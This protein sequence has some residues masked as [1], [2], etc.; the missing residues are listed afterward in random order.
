[1]PDDDVTPESDPPEA[2]APAPDD[3]AAAPEVEAPPAPNPV[4]E[5]IAAKLQAGGL[6][7]DAVVQTEPAFDTLIVRVAPGSWRRAAEVAKESLECDYLSFVSAIDW[8]PAPKEGG[9]DAGGDTSA[10]VQPTETTYGAAGSAGRFQVFA[11]VQSTSRH[12]GVTFKTD[13]DEQSPLV[14]SWVAVYPG[15]EWHER[16]CWEMFGIVFD[17]HPDLR[18]LY[19]PAE[20]AGHPLR[21]DFPLL[22][23]VVKPWPG[24]VDVEPMPES[25]AAVGGEG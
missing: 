21:K 25:P 9:E 17:G 20:F 22:A 18:K 7:S 3:E 10:P 5:K 2:D 8:M 12:W 16:E 19:L 1:M 4:H 6:G 24:L 15:A 23:R 13:V 11:H 14:E